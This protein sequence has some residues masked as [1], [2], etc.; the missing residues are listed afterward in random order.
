MPMRN[1]RRL[2]NVSD[3]RGSS[4]KEGDG[5]GGESTLFRSH[6]W[7]L[8]SALGRI[9]QILGPTFKLS[10]ILNFFHLS[11]LVLSKWGI[12]SA[13]GCQI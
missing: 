10:S 7:N 12:V 4:L 9:F 13:L 11:A 5:G 6:F 8:L 2:L 1:L 3:Y